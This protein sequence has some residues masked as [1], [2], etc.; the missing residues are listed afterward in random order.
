MVARLFLL[1]NPKEGALGHDRMA[2]MYIYLH[3]ME[4]DAAEGQKI[5]AQARSAMDKAELKQIR[6]GK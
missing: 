4:Q 3:A 5:L 2:T 6:G 1:S